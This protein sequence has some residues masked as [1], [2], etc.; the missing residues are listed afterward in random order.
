MATSK[1]SRRGLDTVDYALSGLNF[2][3][4]IKSPIQA[5]QKAIKSG[6]NPIRRIDDKLDRLDGIAFKTTPK[7]EAIFDGIDGAKLTLDNASLAHSVVRDGLTTT[8]FLLENANQAGE[9]QAA[10]M[11]AALRIGADGPGNS[12]AGASDYAILNR[13]LDL[14]SSPRAEAIE[15]IRPNVQ[16][17]RIKV[18]DFNETLDAIDFSGITT[19]MAGLDRIGEL[20]EALKVPLDIASA[21]LE[22]VKP[23]LDA[24]GLLSEL[25]DSVIDFVVET[26]G[27]GGLLD[28]AE[29]AIADLLP[30]A[31]LFDEFLELVQPLYDALQELIN[32]ALGALAM[33][34]DVGLA[35]FGDGMGDALRGVTGWADDSDWVLRGDDDGDVLDALGG[36]DK[37]FAGGGD[38]IIVAGKGSDEIHGEGG[39]DFIHF[40]ASFT[41]YELARDDAGDIIVSHVKPRGSFNSGVDVLKSLDDLDVVAFSDIAFTGRELKDSIIGGSILR[42]RPRPT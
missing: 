13:A 7:K 24:I 17:V 33:L 27:L 28:A 3:S 4:P 37:I 41:E 1:T 42:A 6:N 10:A 34:T 36:D 12:L 15:N 19:Q 8:I 35:A 14:Q 20:L 22:P 32:D 30:S 16:S 40:N 21:A 26:L 39:K 9:N 18:D 23:L 31:N 2:F 25:V 11:N 29:D 38:D 5:L